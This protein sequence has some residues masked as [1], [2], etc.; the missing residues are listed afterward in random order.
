ML[1][2]EDLRTESEK[3][4]ESKLTNMRKKFMELRFSHAS[5]TLKNPIELNVM[6]KDIAR[7][8]TAINEKKNEQK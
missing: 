8:M 3:E 4:L 5:G 6:K 2:I 1:K 7:L